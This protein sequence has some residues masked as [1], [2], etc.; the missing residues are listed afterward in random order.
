MLFQ[1][2]ATKAPK[3]GLS[4]EKEIQIASWLRAA[5][6]GDI[7]FI[8]KNMNLVGSVNKNGTS[9]LMAACARGQ[10]DVARLLL[11]AGEDPNLLDGNKDSALFYS[12]TQ[13]KE[14][15]FDLLM[16]KKVKIH[17]TRD[18]GISPLMIAIDN[19]RTSMAE[20][21]IDAGVNVN[22]VTEDGWSALFFTIR[23][24]NLKMAKRLVKAGAKPEAV[25]RDG[26][27][28]LD[29]ARED[30]WTEGIRYFQQ[31]TPKKS[32]EKPAVKSTSTKN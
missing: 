13:N 12:I 27:T 6:K 11:E 24:K 31:F 32:I 15:S 17:A 29:Y 14:N 3:A 10:E 19:N 18:D 20:K 26:R 4:P 25:D 2:C 5:S 23:L 7:E 1:G 30:K 8:K 21:L 22:E 28:P 9:A 16:Q